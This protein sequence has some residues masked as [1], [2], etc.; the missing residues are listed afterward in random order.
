MPDDIRQGVAMNYISNDRL[1][2]LLSKLGYKTADRIVCR[3]IE[4]QYPTTTAGILKAAADLNI[5]ITL[6]TG[7]SINEE[8][9]KLRHKCS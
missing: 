2:E 3:M 4:A 8:L 5:S 7:I 9:T 6:V 1:R